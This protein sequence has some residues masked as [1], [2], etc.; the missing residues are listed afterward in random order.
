MENRKKEIYTVT[1]MSCAACEQHV[2]RAV[3]EAPGVNKVEVDLLSGKMR[4]EYEADLK[5]YPDIPQIVK[6]AGYHA[7]IEGN[8]TKND[9]NES[10]SGKTQN[11]ANVKSTFNNNSIEELARDESKQMSKRLLISVIFDIPLVFLAMYHMFF[12]WMGIEVPSILLHWFHGAENAMTY[13]LTQ[14]LLLLPIL[15]VN[16]AYFTKGFSALWK[17]HPGMDS[18]IAI[19]ATGSVLYSLYSFV[20]IVL[21]GSTIQQIEG[22]VGNLWFESAGTIL[23][24]VTVGKFL[25]TRSKG[26]T[27]RAISQLMQ[28]APKIALVIRDGQECEIPLEELR[29]E[30]V[31]ILKAGS[32]VPADGVVIEGNAAVD[33]SSITGESIPVEKKEDDAIIAGTVNQNGYLRCKA[34]KVSDDTVL[35]QI[36]RLVEEAGMQKAPIASLADKVAGIFVPVVLVIALVTLVAWYMITGN[37]GLGINYAITVL[38][39]SCPCALGLATPVAVT[40]ATGVGALHGILYKSGEA[41]QRM[42]MANVVLLDKTGTITKGEPVVTDIISVNQD[43]S[44]SQLLYIAARMEQKSEHVLAKAI[45]MKESESKADS[46]S[47]KEDVNFET[48]TEFEVLPGCGVIVKNSDGESFGIGNDTLQNHCQMLPEDDSAKEFTSQY[49]QLQREGKTPLILIKN[50]QPIGI[51]AVADQER[52]ESQ[53]AVHEW[54]KRKKRVIML[55]GD[56]ETT[57]QAIMKRVGIDEVIAHVLPQEK[58]MVVKKLQAEGNQVVMIGDG[59]N[60]APALT[61][62]DVGIAVGAG[63]DIAMES[64]DIVLMHNSLLDAVTAMDLGKRTLRVIKENLFWAFIYNIIGIP[65]AAGVLVPAFGIGITPMFGSA[66]MSLSSLFVV[67]N[68]LRLRFFQPMHCEPQ[69]EDKKMTTK[70]IKIEGMM[71]DH[72]KMHVER[73]L[74]SLEGVEEAIVSLKENNAVL[75]GEQLPK[76]EVICKAIEEAGYKVV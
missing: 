25:E 66:A 10:Y 57:A 8:R 46:N 2:S 41:L 74:S 43:Y 36:I 5:E 37:A 17:R 16:Y 44:K 31:F 68:A 24:L 38:V 18:L 55:T 21:P 48:F 52:E 1:G 59:I 42:A 60:D 30:D 15:L 13:A 23:A 51:I 19:G 11:G 7:E 47:P 3:R 35:A 39:I 49:L 70:T 56:Q 28:L 58:E 69:K 64:A 72:C 27:G 53:K 6:N 20:I 76:D 40:V 4:V 9:I 34:E 14:I 73:A 61:S 29:I 75:K 71:C 12:T 32:R 45:L 67:G 62:A 26:K 22:A 63:T 50:R 65:L 54:K 33:E